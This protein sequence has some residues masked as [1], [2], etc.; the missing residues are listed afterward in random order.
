MWEIFPRLGWPATKIQLFSSR[1]SALSLEKSLWKRTRPG[2]VVSALFDFSFVSVGL[3]SR[4]YHT[5][6]F[7]SI[8]LES[9]FVSTQLVSFWPLGFLTPLLWLVNHKRDPKRSFFNS[10]TLRSLENTYY[11][12]YKCRDHLTSVCAMTSLSCLSWYCHM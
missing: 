6:Y 11:A 12:H 8:V 4:S 5:V 3:K 2:P 7:S 9:S 1:N 10:R